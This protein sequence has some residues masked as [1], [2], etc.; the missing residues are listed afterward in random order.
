MASDFKASLENL[1]KIRRFCLEIKSKNGIVA[2]V[3][4]CT[5]P[6]VEKALDAIPRAGGR[7]DLSIAS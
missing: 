3:P 1:G 5:L 4:L 7:Q 6:G 2:A